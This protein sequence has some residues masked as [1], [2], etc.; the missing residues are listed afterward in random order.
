MIA[1]TSGQWIAIGS[2]ATLF[3]ALIALGTVVVTT[4]LS[5]REATN[6]RINHAFELLTGQTQRR[7]AG[8]SM[9]SG[10]VPKRWQKQ[11]AQLAATQ[12]IYLLTQSLSGDRV[13]EKKNLDALF[14]LYVMYR[15]RPPGATTEEQLATLIEE[16]LDDL[17]KEPPVKP[18]QGLDLDWFE[19]VSLKEKLPQAL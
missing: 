12:A 11:T 15:S 1:V 9:L 17:Q 10:G 8:I 4:I 16:R 18:T 19:L 6:K 7:S 13:D 2:I 14:D 5:N 3:T